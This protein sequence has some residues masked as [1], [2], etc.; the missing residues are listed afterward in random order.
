MWSSM[1]TSYLQGAMIA[2]TTT[3]FQL[4]DA[5]HSRPVRSY[6][7]P[8][9]YLPR[10]RLMNGVHVVDAS[11]VCM[12]YDRGNIIQGSFVAPSWFLP[13]P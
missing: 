5:V 1:Q 3:S 8:T 9:A 7:R 6:G 12:L 4:H 10:D 2:D 13:D 11:D